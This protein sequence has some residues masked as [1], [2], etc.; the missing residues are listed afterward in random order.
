[1]A[2][3]ELDFTIE[4]LGQCRF[5]S[6]MKGVRFAG[7][8]DRVLFHASPSE[9]KQHFHASTRYFWPARKGNPQT[10]APSDS[11]PPQ[12][13]L[14]KYLFRLKPLKTSYSLNSASSWVPYP[15][16]GIDVEFHK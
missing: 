16:P 11:A 12:P 2:D 1:M 14:I 5:P 15:I 3:L 10:S 6:P 8:D 9:V 7:D 4:R 13:V